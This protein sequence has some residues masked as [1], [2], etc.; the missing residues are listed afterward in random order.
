MIGETHPQEITKHYSPIVFILCASSQYLTK[1]SDKNN[2][3]IVTNKPQEL[4]ITS[5]TMDI[6]TNWSKKQN[7][8]MWFGTVDAG[9]TMAHIGRCM[10]ITNT[11]EDAEVDF[12]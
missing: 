10:Q 3:Q 1:Y 12:Q 2:H 4:S 11:H 6:G 9:Y 7:I 8:F 5:S